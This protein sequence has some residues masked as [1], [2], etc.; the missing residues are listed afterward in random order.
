MYTVSLAKVIEEMNLTNLTPEVDISEIVLKEPEINRPALQ[1]SGFFDYFDYERM[2]IIGNVEHAYL[3]QMPDKGLAAFKKILEFKLPCV[4]FCRGLEVIDSF[5]EAAVEA[6]VPLLAT[7]KMTT[8]FEGEAMRWLKVELAPRISI[9]G[10]LVDI[11]GEGVLITGESGVGKS[12]TAIELM[13]RGHRLIADDVVVIKKVSDATLIGSAPEIT[14]HLIE[15][16][17]VGII[18]ARALFGVESVKLTQQ[19]DLVVR[20]EDWVKDK[21]YDRMG[22]EDHYIEYLGNKV[23]C[24]DVPIRPGRNLAVILEAAAKNHR[25]KK[26]GYNAA[27]E[28]TKRVTENI[29]NGGKFTDN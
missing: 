27:L 2:Q 16:R 23:V 21:E 24:H 17:G 9:H 8:D 5:K 15:M 19:I 11:D 6:G 12:E 18:D 1:L 10:V 14:R 22:I 25:L 26:M 3:G 29:Q 28:F 20:L 13:N 4:V 7:E